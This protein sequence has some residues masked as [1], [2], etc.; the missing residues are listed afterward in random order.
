MKIVFMSQKIGQNEGNAFFWLTAFKKRGQLL[1]IGSLPWSLNEICRWQP[2]HIH[3]DN[4][5]QPL[6]KWMPLNRLRKLRDRL[7]NTA[8][9]LYFHD[10]LKELNY[11]P[12]LLQY[13]DGSFCSYNE[14]GSIWMPVPSDIKFWDVPRPEIPKHNIIFIGNVYK[15]LTKAQKIEYT[16]GRTLRAVQTRFKITIVGHG[17]QKEYGLHHRPPTGKFQETRAYYQNARIG[18]NVMN[19][20]IRNLRK[21]WSNRLTH[22]MLSGLPCF[23]PY[24]PGLENAFID[25]KEVIFYH[26]DQ[27]LIK[28]L[29]SYTKNNDLLRQIG[30]AGKKKMQGLGDINKAVNRILAVKR[31]G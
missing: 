15:Q 14:K 27:D 19:D 16:R 7:G 5:A 21:C 4:A 17:W 11:R 12:G 28:K 31:T 10:A 25:G 1:H 2:D 23:T 20:S 26:S 13:L 3:I 29:A 24:M 9:T 18:L 6:D 22:M 30:Q 8:I